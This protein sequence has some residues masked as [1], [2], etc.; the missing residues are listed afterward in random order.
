MPR[1]PI[2][3]MPVALAIA[4]VL[5]FY[6]W[7]ASDDLPGLGRVVGSG[8]VSIGAPFTLTDQDGRKRSSADF[9]GRYMLIYFGY[10]YCPDVCP[11]TLSLMADALS[12]VG[13]KASRVVPIFITI[14]P[15]RDTPGQL[16]T[17]LRAF[18]PGFVGLTG[19]LKTITRVGADYRVYFRKHPLDGGG[20]G[21]DHSSVIYLMGPDGKYV[22]Y[23]DDTAIGP[24]KLAAE[25][26]DRL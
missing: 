10:S 14:D 23:W 25:L 24:D 12:K 22:T 1:L 16:K 6:L 26:R 15:E 7:H 19:D 8:S 20:Y 18:G 9:S 2:I 17:Y 11:T 13:P 21:L 5:G 3:L 4:L